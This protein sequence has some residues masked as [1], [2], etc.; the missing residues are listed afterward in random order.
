MSKNA[1]EVS[2]VSKSFGRLK[3]LNNVSLKAERGKVTG[4]LG[5]NGAGKSTLIKVM[6]TLLE[7]SSGKVLVDGVDVLH[8]PNEARKRLGLA[9][10]YAAV[11][12]FLTGRETLQMVA[13]LYG[14][15]RQTSRQKSTELLEQLDLVAAGDRQ[16]KTYSGGMRRRLDLGASLVATPKVLFLD[17]PTT[18]LD[19]RTRLQLWD[20]IRH[21][22]DQG[23]TILLTTQ[24]LE[25]ADALCD[26]IYVIDHG[27]MIVQGSSTELKNSLGQDVIELK[28]AERNLKKAAELLT[29]EMKRDVDT[30][31]LT[32]EL[33]LKSKHGA[34]DIVMVAGLLKKYK[35]KA[36]ELSLHRPSLDDVFL[37]VTG[38]GTGEEK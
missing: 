3:A 8:N 4:L 13:R 37:A 5:P 24:Y 22:V 25:E 34:D 20:I 27:K 31:T 10:Q 29:T 18:G 16:I 23:V 17:E 32:R 2:G 6:T 15:D 9:G 7:P 11:D 30:D 26:Y 21:L 38:K 35:I 19:P 1:I 36:E 12:G 14:M 33:R 28:V